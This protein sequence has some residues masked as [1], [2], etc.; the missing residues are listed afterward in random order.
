MINA[1]RLLVGATLTAAIL[2]GRGAIADASTISDALATTKAVSADL[3]EV[4]S[5]AKSHDSAALEGACV[6][7]QD[8]AS[9]FLAY[10]H[11][12]R[13]YPRH[14]WTLSRA[15]MRLYRQAGEACESGA[16]YQSGDDIRHAITL[17]DLANLKTNQ[18]A[19]AM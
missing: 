10:H 3:G 9:T 5:A 17:L 18:A 14:A 15:G 12:P 2:G 19:A 6:A 16:R 4:A 8:D 7:L 1:K 11:R 13:A